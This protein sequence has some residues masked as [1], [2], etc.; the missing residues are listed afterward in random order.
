VLFIISLR[1]DMA[2][3]DLVAF[4]WLLLLPAVCMAS[5]LWSEAPGASLRAG[6]QL[7]LTFVIAI[8]VAGV[9]RPGRS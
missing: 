6:M 5:V 7:F 9:C 1:P 2:G 8:L 3:R 4:R